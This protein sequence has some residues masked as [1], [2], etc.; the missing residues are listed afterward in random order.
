MS[1]RIRR[2]TLYDVEQSD[3]STTTLSE[4][5]EKREAWAERLEHFTWVGSRYYPE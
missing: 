5:G 2:P 1:Q 4:Q 3:E